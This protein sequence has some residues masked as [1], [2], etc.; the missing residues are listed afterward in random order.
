M[1]QCIICNTEHDRK[2]VDG[3]ALYCARCS[4]NKDD[5]EGGISRVLYNLY[6]G[7]IIAGKNFDGERLCVYC[8]P[9][10]YGVPHKHIPI[11]ETR[12][13]DRLDRTARASIARLDEA[14][15][16]I[17]EMLRQDKRLIVHCHG[18]VERSP[19]TVAW[20]LARE[21][22][23]RDLD[24]AYEFL[25]KIRPVVANRLSWLPK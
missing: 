12:P 13:K 16:Y 18:G 4:R 24:A 19:L 6:L 3:P 9:P 1:T 17:K 10:D 20:F 14:A 5:A 11:L 7:D 2:W 15:D 8:D 21:A 25:Q 23:C 22:V